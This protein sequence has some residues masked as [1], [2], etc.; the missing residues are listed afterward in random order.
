MALHVASRWGVSAIVRKLIQRDHNVNVYDGSGW[1]PLQNAA[2]YGHTKVARK[3][4]RAKA[5]VH[6]KVKGPSRN[7]LR[8]AAYYIC[9]I[10]LKI[11]V[12][13]T[14]LILDAGA[15]FVG[16][17]GF[18]EGKT[19]LMLAAQKGHS[20]VVAE[21]VKAG[22]DINVKDRNGMTAVL[23][24]WNYDVIHQ[25]GIQDAGSLKHLSKEDRSRV[26]WHACDEGDLRMVQSVIREGCDVDHIHKG[27]TPV[28]MAT[29]R[30]HDR[31]VKELILANCDVNQHSKGYYS[32]LRSSLSL[33]RQ[34]LPSAMVS[35]AI[36]VPWFAL[37]LSLGRLD[38]PPLVAPQWVNA[39][40]GSVAL[41][42]APVCVTAAALQQ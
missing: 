33:G 16:Q 18:F 37:G 21:L 17:V 15:G 12:L 30:G 24:A 14:R 4:I 20:A 19:A 10:I 29:L 7:V 34:F 5:D 28:M 8:I 39:W 22:A 38:R 27:Q 1:T 25:L 42:A 9:Q 41:L 13:Y 36:L 32:D 40:T 31:I 6:L 2:F 11:V 35:I 26:L 3:L 23:L